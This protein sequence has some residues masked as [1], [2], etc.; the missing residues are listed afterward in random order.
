MRL[1]RALPC[2]LAAL[3]L[4]PAAA[5]AQAEDTIYESLSIP[6]VDGDR[7]HV[8]VARPKGVAKAPVI[9]TYSPYNSLSEGTTPNLAYDELGLRCLPK[10]YAR[11]VADVLGTRNS[12]AAGTT[13][14]ARSSSRASTSSTRSPRSRGPTARSR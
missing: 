14:G 11:A 3:A 12:S 6:T 5:Q 9:L 8:E 10:G 7:I 2:A 4:L 1:S 13:A